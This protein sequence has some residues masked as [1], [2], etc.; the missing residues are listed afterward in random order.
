MAT[1]A[2]G[3]LQPCQARRDGAF[4][5]GGFHG[6]AGH[7]DSRGSSGAIASSMARITI[8]TPAIT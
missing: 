8:G 1:S 7:R 3:F 6:D 5:N 4:G 2:M